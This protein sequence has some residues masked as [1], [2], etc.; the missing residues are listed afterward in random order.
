MFYHE[1][2]KKNNLFIY[3]P[4]LILAFFLSEFYFSPGVLRVG[5]FQNGL[6]TK[7]EATLEFQAK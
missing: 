5:S 2:V 1:T 6:L 7:N 3:V 4:T